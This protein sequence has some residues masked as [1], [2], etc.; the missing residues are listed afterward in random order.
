MEWIS[1]CVKNVVKPG[2]EP[3]N[4]GP[5]VNSTGNEVFPFIGS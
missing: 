1:T 4:L 3:V 5:K 2:D